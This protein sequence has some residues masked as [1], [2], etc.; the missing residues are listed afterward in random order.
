M[1]N[2]DLLVSLDETRLNLVI[3][4]VYGSPSARPLFSGAQSG[5]QSGINY[6]LNWSVN[7]AP[8]ISLRPPSPEEWGRAAKAGGVSVA[9]QSSAAFIAIIPSLTIKLSTGDA[10]VDGTWPVEAICT[11]EVPP[12]GRLSI[13]ALALLLDLSQM[14]PLDQV[15]IVQLLVP[16][17]LGMLRSA[18]SGIQIPAL[19]FGGISL[20]SPVVDIQNGRLLTAF[21]LAGRGTPA[22]GDGPFPDRSFF[23]LLSPNLVQCAVDHLVQTNIQGQTFN[24]SGS[25]GAGGF[26]A[27]YSVWGRIA[28]ISASTTTNATTLRANVSVEMSASGGINVPVLGP[29]LDPNTYKPIIDP[30][31][32]KPIIDPNTYKHL[33]PTS[34]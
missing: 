17:I 5:E 8:T 9:P 26:S 32:Y 23:A 1:S 14:S 15:I 29:I 13:N 27:N 20:A 28:G 2:Y 31:T 33:D 24:T 34:W 6:T 25:E 22:I 10:G 16:Q 11:A 4:Q 3:S 19:N 30:N 21:N 12:N 18:L 7:A